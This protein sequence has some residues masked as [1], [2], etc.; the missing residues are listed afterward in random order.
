MA[1]FGVAVGPAAHRALRR[2][3]GSRTAAGNVDRA[4][5]V[6]RGAAHRPHGVRAQGVVDQGVAA[7][8]GG[9]TLRG[10]GDPNGL[11]PGPSG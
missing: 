8:A 11:G 5:F 4:A 1:V 3:P 6:A 9:A 7:P 10:T 2:S